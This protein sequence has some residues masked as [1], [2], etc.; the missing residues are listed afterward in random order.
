M[1]LKYRRDAMLFLFMLI[2]VSLAGELKFHPFGGYFS[3][4]QVSLGSPVFLLF[5]LFL[6]N[7]SLVF[8][9]T[10]MGI[11]VVIFRALIDVY[12]LGEPFTKAIWLHSATFFY[13]FVYAGC[14]TFPKFDRN[15]M[16]NK[17]VQIAVWSIAAE[18][19]AS[20]AELSATNILVNS[21]WHVLTLAMIFKLMCIAVLR[22]FFILSFFFLA[23]LYVMETRMYREHKENERMLLWITDLYN[24]VI[25]LNT[26][27][28]NAEDAT[29]KCYKI[30]EELESHAVTIQEKA[31][32]EKMLSMAGILHEIKKDNQRIYAGLV[33]LTDKHNDEMADYLSANEIAKLAIGIHKKYAKSLGK[34]I[35]FN[36]KVLEQL[37]LLHVYTVLSLINNLMSNAVEAINKI[38]TIALIIYAED[39]IFK[40]LV[41][42]TGSFIPKK[43]LELVFQPGYTTKFDDNGNASTGVGLPYVKNHVESLGG[44]INIDSDGVD[45]VKCTLSIP[46]NKLKGHKCN[47]IYDCR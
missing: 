26:S 7:K 22:C 18:I 13:Y 25:Q 11:F 23:Q 15:Y 10:C 40:I 42:N 24:E 39:N 32:A 1:W 37:P 35:V 38:G 31:L 9:G 44:S 41:T 46:L 12:S 4:F 36:M 29:R 20:I 33:A 3:G 17:A 6:R 19:A 47:A 5:I 45:N 2:C 43:R 16:Y 28:R 34:S 8:T 27:Q 21:S 14:F 30:Y